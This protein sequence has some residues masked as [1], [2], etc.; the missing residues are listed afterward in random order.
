MKLEELLHQKGLILSNP[1]A[2]NIISRCKSMHP[3]EIKLF[4]GETYDSLGNTID[5][6]KYYFFTAEL[7]D[8]LREMGFRINPIILIADVAACR[9]VLPRLERRYM[10]LGKLRASFV[11]QVNE[12]YG[13][14]LNVV[15]MS[16]YL[17]THEFQQKVKDVI[18]TC[19]LDPSL[20]ERVEK[21][22]PE[23]KLD[24]EKKKGFMYSFDEIATIIDL[25]IKIGPPR[26][27]LYDN[28]AREI[29]SRGDKKPLMSIFLTPTFPLGTNWAY[30]FANEGI[31][32]YGIT[33]YKAGSKKLQEHRIIVG[34]S[35]PE[36][37]KELI[38]TSFLS[39][40]PEFPNPIL[41]I[42]IIS[43]MARKRIEKDNS[44]ITLYQDYY[45]GRINPSELR[46]KIWQN[47]KK[48]IL[49]KF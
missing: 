20:M 23:S 33:A 47:T 4:Y 9:N 14:N 1:K 34:R 29:A 48:Y 26:E 31:E 49:S 7:S 28:I 17:H 32:E 2:D 18:E 11:E 25:D 39:T 44:P 5:S 3:K 8:S 16:D 36:S 21:S 45:L 12:I 15:K 6:M 10:Q 46:G 37:V 30:F 27:D 19:N 35:R 41:D 40:E 24:I 42:G 38:Y 13:T 43:E 22:V